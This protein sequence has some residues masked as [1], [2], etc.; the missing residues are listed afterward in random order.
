MK[1]DGYRPLGTM[2]KDMFEV[3]AGSTDPE[4][5]RPANYL[6]FPYDWRRDNAVIARRLKALI[7]E[8]LDRWRRSSTERAGAKVIFIAHSMGGL[9]CRYYTEVL[10]GWENC[11]AL[12]TLGTPHRGS[13][14]ALE[15]LSC[16]YKNAVTDLTEVVRTF[17]SLYQLLPIYPVLDRGGYVLRIAECAALPG[18]VEARARSALAFHRRIE[19]A[20]RNN[21]KG[22]AD[23]GGYATIPLVGKRQPTLQSA[24]LAD[25]LVKTSRA[26]P[27]H[28]DPLLSDGDGTV[29]R[30][31]AV[32]IEMGEGT[33]VFPIAERHSSLPNNRQVFEWLRDV[34][35]QLQ[36]R[37][38][39]ALRSP[40]PGEHPEIG[41]E[42][43][44][45]Y[46][47]E[48]PVVLRAEVHGGDG[49]PTARVR[50]TVPGGGE[51]VAA[52]LRSGDSWELR[53]VGLDPGIYRVTVEVV[54][55]SGK[56]GLPV[57]DLFEVAH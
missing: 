40:A 54:Q 30:A 6:E 10:G 26:L 41:L 25:G 22:G 16:G 9:I 29:P 56:A 20:V 28:V 31:S 43:E 45:V 32:P 51:A 11:R 37:G 55:P 50:S 19:R 36:V 42:L 52:F 34:L 5:R 13:V 38:L 23:L 35:L 24:V 18:V 53:L 14:S 4:D 57:H 49:T 46:S 8:R 27:R 17:P 1:C 48:A 3:V 15:S 47:L 33:T 7:D 39:T 12:I 2:I 21:R 44:D